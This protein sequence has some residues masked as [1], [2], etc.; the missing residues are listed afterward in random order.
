M[1]LNYPLYLVDTHIL[2]LR[3]EKMAQMPVDEAE[4]KAPVSS[5]IRRLPLTWWWIATALAV[6]LIIAATFLFLILELGEP[7]ALLILGISIASALSPLVERLDK[8]MPRALAVVVVYLIVALFFAL[9]IWIVVPPLV[10]QAQSAINQLPVFLDEAQESMDEFVFFD[11]GAIGDTIVNQLGAIT[12]QVLQVPIIIFDGF[13][14]VIMILFISIYWLIIKPSIWRF[15]LSLFNPAQRDRVQHIVTKMGRSMGGYFRGVFINGLIVAVISTIGLTIIGVPFPIVLG[16]LA[17]LGEFVP[18]VGPF[19]AG[20]L[21]VL[22]ALFV[23]PTTALITLIFVLIL[24][25]FEGQILTPNI[26]RSQ[27]E[28]SPLMVILAILA[29]SALGGLMGAIVAIPVMAAL[30]VFIE[31]IVAPAIR[32]QTGAPPVR[33]EDEENGEEGGDE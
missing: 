6:A 10:Q 13:F 12:G 21:M 31:E 24:Q 23:S 15:F 33:T 27:T 16:I 19:L 17:G 8:R 22:M 30:R 7:L 26:M 1:L 29:G 11:L 28:V 25:Q 14:N 3:G 5:L 18:M 2:F 4:S 9:L 32:R 20:S